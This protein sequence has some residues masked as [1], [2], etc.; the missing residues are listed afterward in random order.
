MGPADVV[1]HLMGFAMPALALA[2]LLPLAARLLVPTARGRS[3]W[4]AFAAN[5]VTG[6]AALAAGLWYFGR[7]GKMATYAALVLAVASSQWLCARGWRR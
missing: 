7:D 4:L 5:F 2:L 1:F 3:W 6:L